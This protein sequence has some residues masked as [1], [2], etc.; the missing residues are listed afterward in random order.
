[1]RSVVINFYCGNGDITV[2]KITQVSFPFVRI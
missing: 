1:M 2:K